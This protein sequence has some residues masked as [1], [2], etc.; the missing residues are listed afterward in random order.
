M[1]SSLLGAKRS[2]PSGGA[3]LNYLT[4]PEQCPYVPVSRQVC[5]LRLVV[6]LY[7]VFLSLTRELKSFPSDEGSQTINPLRDFHEKA[8]FL[9]FN[10]MFMSQLSNQLLYEQSSPLL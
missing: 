10:G 1:S 8:V 2:S 9:A 5:Y 3:G 6:C 4:S 7:L